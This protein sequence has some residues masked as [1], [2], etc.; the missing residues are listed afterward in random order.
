MQLVF[1]IVTSRVGAPEARAAATASLRAR[2]GG[3]PGWQEVWIRIAV[4]RS[5]LLDPDTET[6]RRGVVELLHIPAR[7]EPAPKRLAALALAE[8]AV[9]CRALGDRDV[10]DA[11]RRD[12]LERFPDSPAARWT[13]IQTW[14]ARAALHADEPHV[15]STTDSLAAAVAAEGTPTP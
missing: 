14:D 10:A 3:A 9:A 6:R 5:M 11:L 4:G 1:E 8:A 2:L 13:P 7:L 15:T 12:L